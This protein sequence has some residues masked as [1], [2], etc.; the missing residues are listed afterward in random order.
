MA[1]P[2]LARARSSKKR[3]RLTNTNTAALTSKNMASLRL[4]ITTQALNANATVVPSATSTS[5]FGVS[6][7]RAGS[8]AL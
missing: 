6:A 2:E 1:P 8:V 5:M 3:P 7:R 4:A